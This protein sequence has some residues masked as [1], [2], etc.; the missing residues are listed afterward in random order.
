MGG[1]LKV[2]ATMA[3]K[4]DTEMDRFDDNSQ[5]DGGKDQSMTQNSMAGGGAMMWTFPRT[6]GAA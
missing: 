3:P 6:P 1:T 2:R 4:I 5:F